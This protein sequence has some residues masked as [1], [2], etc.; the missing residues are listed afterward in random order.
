ME[1]RDIANVIRNERFFLGSQ[2]RNLGLQ[3]LLLRVKHLLV[4]GLLITLV[5]D[6]NDT[7][8]FAA[9]IATVALHSVTPGNESDDDGKNTRDRRGDESGFPTRHNKMELVETATVNVWDDS[10]SV[11]ATVFWYSHGVFEYTS[12]RVWKEH[13]ARVGDKVHVRS[14]GETFIKMPGHWLRF[15]VTVLG[16]ARNSSL[17]GSVE[18]VSEV[19]SD[20]I[21]NV[22]D[23]NFHGTAARINGVFFAPFEIRPSMIFE[24]LS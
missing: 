5:G 17:N 7:A 21:Y 3:G 23:T 16:G 8:V 11:G 18:W 20:G 12:G 10:Y 22:I 9:G 15:D 19:E 6:F 1:C 24:R 14:T 2:L 13:P 4:V